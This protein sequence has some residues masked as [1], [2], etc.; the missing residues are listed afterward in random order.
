MKKRICI[1]DGDSTVLDAI[2]GLIATNA[3]AVETFISTEE[4]LQHLDCKNT[5]CVIVDVQTPEIGGLELQQILT[6]R[7]R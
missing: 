4:F 5:A 6:I 7:P 3:F 1:V 2:Q